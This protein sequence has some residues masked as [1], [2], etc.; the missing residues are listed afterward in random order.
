[1][2]PAPRT[3]RARAAALAL[4]LA[5]PIVAATATPAFA[6]GESTSATLTSPASGSSST[7]FMWSYTFGGGTHG[8]SNI[9]I[10]FCPSVLADVVSASPSADIFKTGN[11]PGGHGTFGPGVKFDLTAASG[12]FSVTF[13]SAHAIGTGTVS[14]Q[15]H[16]GD[17]QNPDATTFA[18]G[19]SCSTD[20]GSGSTDQ[21]SGSTDQGSGSTDQGS[22]STDQGSGTTDQGSGSTDQ[23]S[24][25]T[26]QGS[27]STDQ[28]SGTTDTGDNPQPQ[29]I[30][31]NH[32]NDADG[33]QNAGQDPAD[34]APTTVVLGETVVNP[35]APAP[36][37]S[38][39]TTPAV[40]TTQDPAT[41]SPAATPSPTA[42]LAP[43]SAV[44]GTGLARTG[45]G[46]TLPELEL[47]MG[48][49]AAGLAL[50]TAR[51][52]RKGTSASSAG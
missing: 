32:G 41:P 15:S 48:L 44:E 20:P 16:S 35:P 21:G 4:A 31:D 26:D 17:G 8:L 25:T 40:V 45:A 6:S 39:P 30:V 34:P 10:G 49:L 9:A 1:L 51:R 38:D 7:T 28:G 11:V 14:V 12:T 29:T 52:K 50:R 27:G 18:D 13:G 37:P 2:L 19:P 43:T 36:T 33:N 23:G 47:G 3:R 5:A 46:D 24:G 42:T 22:G